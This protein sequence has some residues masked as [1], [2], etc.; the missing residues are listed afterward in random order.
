MP[1]V[2]VRYGQNLG[3]IVNDIDEPTRLGYQFIGWSLT[4]NGEVIDGNVTMP[5]NQT[6]LYAVWRE[7]TNASYTVVTCWKV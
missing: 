2:S 7:N 5:A 3:T 6:S 1:S 4:N